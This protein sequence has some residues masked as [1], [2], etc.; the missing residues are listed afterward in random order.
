MTSKYKICVVT[1]TRAEYGL[2]SSVIK[3]I[4]D[5]PECELQLIVTGTHL[6]PEFGLTYKEIESDG[7]KITRKIPVYQG[8]DEDQVLMTIATASSEIGRA[9][10]ELKPNMV[11]LLGDRYELL[12]IASACVV[13]RI[14]I[15][16]ISGG[17]VSEGA[18]DEYIRHAVSKLS[19]LHFTSTEAYRDRVIQLGES[20]ERVFNVGDLGIENIQHLNR[21]TK[22]QLEDNIGISIGDSM[23]QVTFHPTTLEDDSEQQFAQLLA[24]LEER[25]SFQIVFTRPNA[26]RGSTA[27]NRM[28]DNFI[29]RNAHRSYAFASLGY[30]RFLSLVS[31]CVAMVGNSSSGVV[32]VPSLKVGTINIGNRQR[33][34]ICSDSVLHCKP[35]Q[36]EIIAALDRVSSDAYRLK[37]LETVNPYESNGT[38]EQIVARMK[39]CLA[40][41]SGMH[42]SFYRGD[43]YESH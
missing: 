34:R 30:M 11:V 36:D 13:L 7:I 1:A 23:L 38:S 3:R 35:D 42:K 37:M 8:N 12:P 6:A 14:P 40:N 28:I 4:Q 5:D 31:Y 17:E 2:L 39:E 32:E 41:Y 33:G 18:Y 9:L 15:A 29:G 26:D 20:P 22:E 24:A 10:I 25:P 21:M 19:Y 16:H 43:R 27:L